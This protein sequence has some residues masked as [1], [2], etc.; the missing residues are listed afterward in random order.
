MQFTGNP[1]DAEQ[2]HQQHNTYTGIGSQDQSMG[3]ASALPLSYNASL[4]QQQGSL[5]LPQHQEQ[6][7]GSMFSEQLP[8][9]Y[10]QAGGVAQQEHYHPPAQRQAPAG[11]GHLGSRTKGALGQWL[12]GKAH[13]HH[14]DQFI[15]PA[16]LCLTEHAHPPLHPR[17]CREEATAR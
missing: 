8:P 2:V 1:A 15:S 12:F 7:R 3:L 17:M 13:K 11:L 4:L 16:C 6:Q 9:S 10:E 5:D 14:A